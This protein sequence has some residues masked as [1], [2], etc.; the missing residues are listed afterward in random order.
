MA[1]KVFV[2][3]K[4]V[5]TRKQDT[6]LHIPYTLPLVL[7]SFVLSFSPTL[8][9]PEGRVLGKAILFSYSFFKSPF[10]GEGRVG[11]ISFLLQQLLYRLQRLFLR[12][13]SP[14]LPVIC[15]Y[16]LK[17]YLVAGFYTVFN[18]VIVAAFTFDGN[19]QFFNFVAIGY[20]V[21]TILYPAF[22]Q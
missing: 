5:R 22:Q 9:S 19:R 6:S 2:E 17:H 21:N 15:L 20:G 8:P 1:F 18:Q 4:T 7:V 13:I 3:V 11:C 12:G 16:R 14:Y 10:T